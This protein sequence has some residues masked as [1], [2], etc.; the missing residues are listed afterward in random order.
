[1]RMTSNLAFAAITL[2]LLAACAT[3]PNITSNRAADYT[4]APKRIFVITDIGT[5]YGKQ[6]ADA[7]QTRFIAAAKECGAEVQMLRTTPLDVDDNAQ[8]QKI[9]AFAP[10]AILRFRRNGGT[11]SGGALVHVIYDA[12]LIDLP[13]TKSV[14]RAVVNFH[15]GSIGFGLVDRSADMAADIVEKMKADR[16]LPCSA[17]VP[18]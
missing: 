9:R 8:A 5:E 6:Y 13:T 2:V 18:S 11:N 16:L 3:V 14:W 17:K 7:F 15:M 4:G 1:M 10:D 12:R